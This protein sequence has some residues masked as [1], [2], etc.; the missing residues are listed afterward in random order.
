VPTTCGVA[1]CDLDRDRVKEMVVLFKRLLLDKTLKP[2]NAT[3]TLT[4]SFKDGT[5]FEAK[6]TV[7]VLGK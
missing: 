5:T 3:I 1:I 6:D 2:G 4:G 7:R